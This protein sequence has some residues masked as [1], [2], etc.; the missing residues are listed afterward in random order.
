MQQPFSVDWFSSHVPQWTKVLR[1]RTK[2]THSMLFVGVHEGRAPDWVVR[3]LAPK[4][5]LTVVDDFKYDAC[6]YYLGKPVAIPPVEKTFVEV[7]RLAKRK[8]VS[9]K[10]GLSAKNGSDVAL[11]REIRSLRCPDETFDLVYIDAKDGKH[12][13][14]ALVR[15][16]P[17]VKPGGTIVVTNNVHGRLHDASC[18]K[19]G[20]R[21][22]VDAHVTDVK[23]LHDGFHLFMERRKT[24]IRLP[25]PCRY[26]IYDG[27]ESFEPAVCDGSKAT[28]RLPPKKKGSRG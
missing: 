11:I 5:R 13:M 28:A 7:M 21:G 26:E 19:L 14:D 17:M 9:S 6:A 27:E 24:P 22:F 18:P 1:K 3:N 2:E 20:I 8:V 12:V 25:H 23:V 4:A 16:L 10:R 15:T